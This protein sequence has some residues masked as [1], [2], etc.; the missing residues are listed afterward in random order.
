LRLSLEKAGSPSCAPSAVWALEYP[1]QK[2]PELRRLGLLADYCLALEGV[3]ALVSRYRV[4]AKVAPTVLVQGTQYGMWEYALEIHDQETAKTV[5]TFPL[6][7]A[8]DNYSNRTI[9]CNKVEDARQFEQLVPI[10]PDERI[11]TLTVTTNEEPAPFPTTSRATSEDISTIARIP[12]LDNINSTNNISEDGMVWFEHN[13]KP[14]DSRGSFSHRG[15]FL[16]TVVD[17]QLRRTLIRTSDFRTDWITGLQVTDKHIRFVARA[18]ANAE[19]TLLEYSREGV[20]K[21]AL[22]LSSEQVERLK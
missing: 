2:L 10:V 14:D 16:V 4:T 22:L 12:G 15:Y 21:R 7:I 6:F 8:R 13:Y 9:A 1:S 5:A 18:Q 19:S 3:D 11:A 20:P 17:G